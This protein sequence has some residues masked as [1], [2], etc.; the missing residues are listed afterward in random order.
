MVNKS[1][2]EVTWTRMVAGGGKNE[3]HDF[4]TELKKILPATVVLNA[5]DE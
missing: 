3:C 2:V 1:N 4:K 5:V